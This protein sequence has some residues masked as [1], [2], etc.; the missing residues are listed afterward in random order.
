MLWSIRAVPMRTLARIS[1]G[2]LR[3]GSRA[4]EGQAVVQSKCSPGTPWQ[5]MQAWRRGK[6][7]GVPASALPGGREKS[8]PVASLRG[9]MA[10]F[11]Q[12]S[13]Q[14]KQRMQRERNSS[15]GTAPG[16]RRPAGAIERVRR[17]RGICIVHVASDE[18]V[19][20]TLD[21]GARIT[22]LPDEG[23][24]AAIRLV[25]LGGALTIAPR[26]AGI[27][28]A[29]ADMVR[30]GCGP[31][32]AVAYRRRIDEL[33]ASVGTATTPSTLSLDASFPASELVHLKYSCLVDGSR[34]HDALGFTPRYSLKQTVTDVD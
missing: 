34:A 24:T 12:A 14:R 31:W 9:T 15:S 23:R 33:A 21:S 18:P 3:T 19:F 20:H 1:S 6:I 17:D 26:A 5:S 29:W 28:A 13:P 7:I 2:S 8:A 25:A 16:G 22:V 4:P 11:G 32:D 27:A 30:A 10:R